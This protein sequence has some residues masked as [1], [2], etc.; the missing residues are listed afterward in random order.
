[1]LNKELQ[2][3]REAVN[4]VTI[5]IS[6]LFKLSYRLIKMRPI[7][8]IALYLSAWFVY[9]LGLF[10]SNYLQTSGVPYGFFL[11]YS[12]LNFL[13]G[14]FIFVLT[15]SA[16]LGVFETGSFNF[17]NIINEALGK[18]LKYAWTLLIMILACFL[19]G[20]F[21]GFIFGSVSAVIGFRSALL[22]FVIGC[23]LLILFF[24]F[25][26]RIYFFPYIVVCNNRYGISAFSISFKLTKGYFWQ[27]VKYTV[28]IL[29][30]V[31]LPIVPMIYLML[32]GVT[33]AYLIFMPAGI[34]AL[35]SMIYGLIL[36][37]HF[38]SKA[39]EHT[40]SLIEKK[41]KRKHKLCKHCCEKLDIGVTKCTYCG[42]ELTEDDTVIT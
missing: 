42:R 30:I 5:S 1:M 25:P 4:A 23:I 3:I 28:P 38:L 6:D 33:L 37:K 24:W 2:K 32:K 36:Y 26:I 11:L 29:L 10:F 27:I 12:A 35:Y 21:L 13:I 20:L 9:A 18:F 41:K 8:L 31:L 19:S 16:V 34:A 39:T 15:L 17:K 22:S 14:A 40:N 7:K